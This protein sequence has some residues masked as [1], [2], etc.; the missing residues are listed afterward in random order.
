MRVPVKTLLGQQ[1]LV[2]VPDYGTV[3]DLA[4]RVSGA[5]GACRLFFEVRGRSLLVCA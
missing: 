2:D 4:R 3:A 1:L 5:Q